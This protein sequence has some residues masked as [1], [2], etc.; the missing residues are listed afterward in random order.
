M[1]GPV[2]REGLDRVLKS[3]AQLL[4]HSARLYAEVQRLAGAGI[5]PGSQVAE[6]VVSLMLAHVS[7]ELVL[8]QAVRALVTSGFP[9]EAALQVRS[10]YDGMLAVAWIATDPGEEEDRCLQWALYQQAQICGAL[11][12][13]AAPDAPGVVAAHAR[14][15][16]LREGFGARS[17]KPFEVK[18]FGMTTRDLAKRLEVTESH[19]AIYRLASRRVHAMDIDSY[20]ILDPV[21]RHFK[22]TRP[23]GDHEAVQALSSAC[24][25]LWSTAWIVGARLGLGWD[26]TLRA[27]RLTTE[28]SLTDGELP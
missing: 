12:A 23:E 6:V 10:M 5:R 16:R 15:D 27:L 17:P 18:L 7:R 28:P 24:S 13:F 11:D 3:P 4:E 9:A 25:C 20:L 26:A 8:L 19:G 21:R 14:R 2:H 22:F 1:A